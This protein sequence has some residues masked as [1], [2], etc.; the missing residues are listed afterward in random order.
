MKTTAVEVKCVQYQV[1]NSGGL[2][3]FTAYLHLSDHLTLHLLVYPPI[4]HGHK[5]EDHPPPIQI[6][7]QRSQLL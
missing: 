3:L 7:E 5:R 6:P 2:S 4:I 1:I